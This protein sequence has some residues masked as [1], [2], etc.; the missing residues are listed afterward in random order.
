MTEVVARDIARDD[1]GG[2]YPQCGE[3]KLHAPVPAAKQAQGGTSK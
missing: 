2:R 3:M 1:V